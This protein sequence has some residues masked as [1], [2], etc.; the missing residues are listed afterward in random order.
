[1]YRN[2]RFNFLRWPTK[3]IASSQAR[4]KLRPKAPPAGFYFLPPHVSVRNGYPKHYNCAI[5]DKVNPGHCSGQWLRQEQFFNM[6]QS[7]NRYCFLSKALW[8]TENINDNKLNFLSLDDLFQEN[9]HYLHHPGYLAVK[10]GDGRQSFCFL[11]PNDW[12][13]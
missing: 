6:H 7:E 5:P 2:R 11:V 8:M 4:A 9:E 10:H 3:N 13:T 12:H 1:M